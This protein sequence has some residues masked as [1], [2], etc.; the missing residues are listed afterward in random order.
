MSTSSLELLLDEGLLKSA[1]FPVHCLRGNVLG[2][3][4]SATLLR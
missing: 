4:C 3:D 1:S 2:P